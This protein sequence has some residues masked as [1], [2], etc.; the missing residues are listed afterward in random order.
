MIMHIW[1]ISP[2]LA[3]NSQKLINSTTGMVRA[4]GALIK[5]LHSQI[6]AIL[7]LGFDSHL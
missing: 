2:E 4:A 5:V 7:C 6:M 1:H 3:R